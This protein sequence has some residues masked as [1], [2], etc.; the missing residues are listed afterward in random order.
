MAAA[1]LMEV[2]LPLEKVHA[3][4]EKLLQGRVGTT[5][6]P[7]HW[8]GGAP[9]VWT[10][11]LPIPANSHVVVVQLTVRPELLEEF[12]AALLHNARES[13]ANDPGRLR[14]DVSQHADDPQ[15]WILHEVYT[16]PGRTPRTGSRR[17]SSPTTR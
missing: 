12:Q 13:L 8:H 5:T 6:P 7:D 17:T 4:I 1:I 2:G 11:Q 3:D 14:F 16:N 9:V 15:R 10:G